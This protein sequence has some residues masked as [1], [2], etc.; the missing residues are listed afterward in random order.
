MNRAQLHATIATWQ[1]YSSVPLTE[2]DADEIV[3]NV[4]GFFEVLKSW[5]DA[6]VRPGIS[7]GQPD[8]SVVR[9]RK[10]R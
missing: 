4:L 8:A 10:P 5:R 1:P 7:D 2:A 9:A 6:E 3:E